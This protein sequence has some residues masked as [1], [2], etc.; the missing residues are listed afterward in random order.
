[1]AFFDSPKNRALWDR[2]LGSLRKERERRAREGYKPMAAEAAGRA[3][4]G[5][6]ASRRR[7][8][9]SQLEEKLAAEKQQKNGGRKEWSFARTNQ[10]QAGKQQAKEQPALKGRK[11]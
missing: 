4:G 3:A 8:S 10:R 5:E 9:L 2:E 11:L 7:I 6:N 1:M